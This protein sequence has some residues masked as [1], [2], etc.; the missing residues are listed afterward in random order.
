MKRNDL[1]KFIMNGQRQEQVPCGFWLHF[2]QDAQ[3]GEAAV[4]AHVKYYKETGVPIAKMMNEHLYRLDRKMKT[5]KDWLS[6]RAENIEK[7][8]FADFLREIRAFRNRMGEETLILATIHGIFVSACHATDGPGH[9]TDPNNTVTRHLKEDPESVSVGLKEM[10]ITLQRLSLSCIEA[11]A[12]GIYY[13]ALG[14]EEHR[15]SQE[16]FTRYIKPMEMELLGNVIKKGIVFLHICKDS[17]RLSMYNEYPG[18]VVNWA[19]HISSYS[20]RDGAAI[21]PD[22]I[23]M[24]GFDNR[25]G[26]LLSGSGDEIY[27][28]MSSVVKHV[29]R[30]RLIF[31]ADCTLPGNTPTAQI[32]TVVETSRRI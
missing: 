5:P 9:S 18:Q 16:L 22:K 8:Y 30:N 10:A 2:P 4:D 19:E 21:F 12:D 7:S 28:R 32:R 6:I 13:A 3:V 23:I 1:I 20:L 29:D 11:G 24:G 25:S 31:G 15:F 14:G 26:V 17:P 27:A